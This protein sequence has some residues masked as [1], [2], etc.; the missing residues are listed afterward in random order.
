MYEICSVEENRKENVMSK[1]SF[2]L[3]KSKSLGKN[4]K[5]DF[6]K[7]LHTFDLCNGG[8]FISDS[9]NRPDKFVIPIMNLFV[10]IVKR[11]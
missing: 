4:N 6:G 1:V 9:K 11:N 7:H 2:P 8:L 10:S 5:Y 3:F